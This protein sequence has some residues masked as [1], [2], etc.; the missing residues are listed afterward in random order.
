MKEADVVILGAGASGLLCASRAAKRGLKVLLLEHND[1]AGKKILIS[2]GGRCNFT[3]VEVSSKNFT[4]Q[5]E[6]FCKSALSRYS[7]QDFIVLL[8]KHKILYYE[9][10]LGQLFCRTS[11]RDIVQVLEKE[12]L[13][14][15]VKTVFNCKVE[16]VVKEND[17]FHVK[18]NLFEIQA[19]KLVVATGGL[20]VPKV[21]ATD[22]GY[23][24]A[25]SFGLKVT[26]LYPALDGFRLSQEESFLKEL[27]GVSL[28]C[29]IT[30]KNGMKFQENILFTHS[31][32]SGPAALQASLHWNHH[33]EV[34]LNLLPGM[35]VY[36]YLLSEKKAKNK[37][38]LK[39]F[40]SEKLPARLAEFLCTKYFSHLKEL[41]LCSDEDLKKL[42]D[43]L[44]HWS[45][46]PTGTVGYNKAEL[47]RGGV[48]TAELSSKTMEV[49][50]V[51][52]LF[53]IGEVVDVNGWLG[54]YN[55]QWAWAS[56]AAAAESL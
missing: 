6:H 47:T 54:G 51:E 5:N 29:E 35:K 21:G 43:M 49:K 50:K 53:F 44:S 27:S 3:N 13:E 17:L 36:D 26:K 4:S 39:N 33:E 1:Q 56:A 22:F 16:S 31:G 45:I 12:C 11:A 19:P 10:K 2:G 32:L 14:A 18:T 55:F 34:F 28:L 41:C 52:G 8:E 24:L 23:R 7:P 46:K 48:D 9:K 40:L 38:L 15:E 42:A 30:C 37:K 20:S 25:E